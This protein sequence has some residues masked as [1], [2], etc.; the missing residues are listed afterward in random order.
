MVSTLIVRVAFS[1]HQFG[2][3]SA[4]AVVLFLVIFIL[5]LLQTRLME[6]RE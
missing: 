6:E 1:F 4:L 3:A 2:L 5:A